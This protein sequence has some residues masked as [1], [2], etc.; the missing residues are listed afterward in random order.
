MQ[1]V[2]PD[3]QTYHLTEPK[4]RHLSTVTARI[5]EHTDA[6]GKQPDPYLVLAWFVEA[7]TGCGAEQ[8]LELPVTTGREVE[9]FLSPFLA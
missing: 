2:T 1:F 3:G 4:V 5:V 9:K 8:F 6:T 7:V